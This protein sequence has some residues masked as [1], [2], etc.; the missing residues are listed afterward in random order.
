[1]VVLPWRR[2]VRKVNMPRFIPS[3]CMDPT[4]RFP[5]SWRA[6][7]T[8]PLTTKAIEDY[9]RL[10][11]YGQEAKERR[12]R[13]DG[14]KVVNGIIRLPKVCTACQ[15]ALGHWMTFSYLPKSG[16]YCDHC[17]SSYREAAEKEQNRRHYA[18][19]LQAFE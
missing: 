13:L 16:F 17:R 11:Y 9:E 18:R 5:S 3:V 14:A 1:M 8:K 2:Y 12:L 4:I 7:P 19:T 6:L 15:S 10:G